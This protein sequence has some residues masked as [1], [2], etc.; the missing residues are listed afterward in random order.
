MISPHTHSWYLQYELLLVL[1][2]RSKEYVEVID[3]LNLIFNSRKF[4]DQPLAMQER[5]FINASYVHFLIA[6]GKIDGANL[7]IGK[8]RLG[9]FLN[10]VPT[11]SKDKRGLN[12]PILIVQFLFMIIQNKYDEAI[13]RIEAI[14]KYT[15]RYIRKGENLRSHC[16]LNMLLQIPACSFH[17][18]AVLRK[19]EKWHQKLKANPIELANQPHEV[20]IIPYEDLWD[21]IINFLENSFFHVHR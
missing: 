18:A 11:Y 12:I 4:N 1:S 14:K 21:Y 10:S 15:S 9:K 8:F 3:I 20:E 16:F 13:D 7:K 5:W 6:I 2:L 17:R 19:T